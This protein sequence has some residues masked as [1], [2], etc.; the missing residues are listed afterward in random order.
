MEN[1]GFVL[2]K[3]RKRNSR[4]LKS[5]IK[6]IEILDLNF[7]PDVTINVENFAR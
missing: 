1:D 3:S 6:A 7:Q 2:V 5:T 4:K